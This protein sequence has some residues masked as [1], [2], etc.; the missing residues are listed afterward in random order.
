[1]R[2][3]LSTDSFNNYDGTPKKYIKQEKIY[4]KTQK[5]KEIVNYYKMS[6]RSNSVEVYYD[7]T[8]LHI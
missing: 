3:N 4:A 1:M 7:R 6:K 2:K 8:I 5:K